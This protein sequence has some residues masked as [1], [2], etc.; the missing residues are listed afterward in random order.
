[1]KKR[2]SV[3]IILIGGLHMVLYLYI[4]P[5][6]VYPAFGKNGI[7]VVIILAVL[8]SAVVLGTLS[9]ERKNK[10]ERNGKY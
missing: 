8:I 6:M 9:F 4:V 5:F 10:G 3:R 7:T 1:M 2:I